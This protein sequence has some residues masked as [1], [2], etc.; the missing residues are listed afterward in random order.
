VIRIASATAAAIF[1]AGISVAGI[2][3]ASAAKVVPLTPVCTWI[4][5]TGTLNI[6]TKPNATSSV[7][8]LTFKGDSVSAPLPLTETNNYVL[9]TSR[10]LHGYMDV[11]LLK[12]EGCG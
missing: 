9:A 5:N 8:G 2:I 4:V 3:P 11:S 7:L 10:G 6:H 12:S 1:A